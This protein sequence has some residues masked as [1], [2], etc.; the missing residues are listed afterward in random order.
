[1]L[2]EEQREKVRHMLMVNP[3]GFERFVASVVSASVVLELP[4]DEVFNEAIIMAKAKIEQRQIDGTIDKLKGV[5]KALNSL[6][7]SL[8]DE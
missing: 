1:M 2:T 3:E 7:R 8:K 6:W 5:S 4:I